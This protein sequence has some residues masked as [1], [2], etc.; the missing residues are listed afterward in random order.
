[1]KRHIRTLA[2]A[3][4][5]AAL[6]AGCGTTSTHKTA[7]DTSKNETVVVTRT[8]TALSDGTATVW[9]H[10]KSPGDLQKNMMLTCTTARDLEAAYV[11][12]SQTD[13]H[14][15]S[16]VTYITTRE[17]CSITSDGWTECKT[18]ASQELRFQTDAPLGAYCED[19]R[20]IVIYCQHP[21]SANKW[22]CDQ[23]QAHSTTASATTTTSTVDCSA[24]YPGTYVSYGHNCAYTLNVRK[25]CPGYPPF[26]IDSDPGT[27]LE[28][29]SLA[30]GSSPILYQF[31]WSNG[32][33]VTANI[34]GQS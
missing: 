27:Y 31:E 21:T 6:V 10:C 25:E 7:R 33:I 3:A 17:S 20:C 24:D 28:Q 30:P 23:G 5:A 26:V 13:Q 18:P 9:Q 34:C 22:I 4:I 12:T 16:S 29:E 14:A 1:M 15:A 2:I 11:E 8:T 19:S 32:Q